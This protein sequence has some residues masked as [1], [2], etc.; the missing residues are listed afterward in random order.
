MI[1]YPAYDIIR[2]EKQ[3][4]DLSK[5]CFVHTH[6]TEYNKKKRYFIELHGYGQ[7]ASFGSDEKEEID[8][9]FDHYLT[10]L[11]TRGNQ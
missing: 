4:I 6:T 8:L 9:A 1:S 7:T 5:V 11:L 10:Y 3:I 2:N